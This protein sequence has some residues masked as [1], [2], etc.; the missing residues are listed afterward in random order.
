MSR[1]L[2]RRR[3]HPSTQV[4]LSL[5][6]MQ[7][8]SLFA[9]GDDVGSIHVWDA[10]LSGCSGAVLRAKPHEDFV[11]GLAAHGGCL[12]ACSADGRLSVLDPRRNLARLGLSDPQDDELLSLQVLKAGR[13]VALFVVSQRQA[14][15]S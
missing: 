7:Q 8:P 3:L 2:F 1:C 12:L 6:D 13:K 11:S 14:G 5:S 15:S 10:R 4:S 9:C